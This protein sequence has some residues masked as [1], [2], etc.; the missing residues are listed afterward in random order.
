MW[1]L[2]ITHSAGFLEEEGKKE[3]DFFVSGFL[4]PSPHIENIITVQ[5]NKRPSKLSVCSPFLFLLWTLETGFNV[6]MCSLWR[7]EL[8]YLS[9]VCG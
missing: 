3:M 7:S 6:T 4:L 1:E 2:S 8:F 9:E 5:N